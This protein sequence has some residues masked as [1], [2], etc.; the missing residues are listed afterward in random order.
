MS[1]WLSRTMTV[2]QDR[3][4]AVGGRYA[5]RMTKRTDRL[6]A[7]YVDLAISKVASCGVAA[8]ARALLEMGL[9]LE[10]ARR[11]LL[12]PALRRGTGAAPAAQPQPP[13]AAP[14]S[15]R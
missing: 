11:V 8:G 14:A 9:P 6:T 13:A 12:R 1:G 3:T 2:E 5:G 7:F 10:L 4:R 15:A